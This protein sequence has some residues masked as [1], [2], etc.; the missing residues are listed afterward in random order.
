MPPEVGVDTSLGSLGS[1]GSFGTHWRIWKNVVKHYVAKSG[2]LLPNVVI[3]FKAALELSTKGDWCLQQEVSS[4]GLGRLDLVAKNYSTDVGV[5]VAAEIEQITFLDSV[6]H[7]WVR[8]IR[9][10]VK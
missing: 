7:D 4:N 10:I 3:F 9:R 8:I 6:V 2:E 5:L 1:V